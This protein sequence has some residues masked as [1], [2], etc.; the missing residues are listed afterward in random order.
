MHYGQTPEPKTRGMDLTGAEK[1]DVS[2]AAILEEALI[3]QRIQ[4]NPW[5]LLQKGLLNLRNA[6]GRMVKGRYGETRVRVTS[7]AEAA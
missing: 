7:L 3:L 1:V 6:S 5:F 4:S 2:T